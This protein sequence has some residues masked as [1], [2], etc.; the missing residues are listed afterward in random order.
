MVYKS[1]MISYTW[2]RNFDHALSI[3]LRNTLSHHHLRLLL[4]ILNRSLLLNIL[5]WG[6]LLNILN[7][8]LLGNLLIL[9]S[10]R[11]IQRHL[12][13]LVDWLLNLLSVNLLRVSLRQELRLS[14]LDWLSFWEAIVA[15][16]LLRCH[17]LLNR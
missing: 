11:G 10:I 8:D 4:N 7:W 5:N 2:L 14:I 15:R 13:R 6:L 16:L 9:R 17:Y 3:N 1:I 12:V